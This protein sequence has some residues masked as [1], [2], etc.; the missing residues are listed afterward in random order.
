MEKTPT[1]RIIVFG[2]TGAGKTTMLMYLAGEGSPF[3][4]S[5]RLVSDTVTVTSWTTRW[6]EYYA[7]LIDTVGFYDNRNLN[8]LVE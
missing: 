8:L 5:D 1:K 4:P 6:D 3:T 2:K 7:E